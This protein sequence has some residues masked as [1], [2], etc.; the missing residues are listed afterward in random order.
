MGV[1]DLKRELVSYIEDINDEG[2]LL[3]LKEELMF[4][5]KLDNVDITDGLNESDLLELKEL[6]EEDETKDTQTLDEF[7]KETEKWRIR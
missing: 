4:Y 7:N 1:K 6:A 3:L 2:L 5:G